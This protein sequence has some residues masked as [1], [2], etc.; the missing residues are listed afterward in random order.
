MNDIYNPTQDL[1]LSGLPEFQN[2]GFDPT[3]GPPVKRKTFIESIPK[4]DILK[5]ICAYVEAWKSD[6]TENFSRIFES[7][8]ERM[9]GRVEKRFLDSSPLT[10]LIFKDGRKIY[11]EK[12]KAKNLMIVSSEWV[13]KCRTTQR[14]VNE[15]DYLFDD[16]NYIPPK[17]HVDKSL[18]PIEVKLKRRAERE[19]RAEIKR[20]KQEEK[21]YRRIEEI[22]APLGL[23]S[24]I[25]HLEYQ[26]H[27]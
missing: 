6:G 26:H 14:Y 8:I 19:R 7:V 5:D 27:Q 13:E 17:R 16:T 4:S 20:K 10:H 15:L 3:E 18:V 9:G 1:F 24:L 25:F 11:L 2:L 23:D 21:R 22:L 12:A